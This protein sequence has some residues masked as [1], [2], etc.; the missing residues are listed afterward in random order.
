[1]IRYYEASV[2]D[3]WHKGR[4]SRNQRANRFSIRETSPHK[5]L[6]VNSLPMNCEIIL[7]Q[8][9]VERFRYQFQIPSF[10]I[11]LPAYSETLVRI[12]TTEKGNRL[13]EAQKLQENG[14]CAS[15]VVECKDSSFL[16]LI[17]NLNYTGENLKKFPRTQ[18]LTKLSGRFQDATN[19][20]SHIRKQILQS[21][22]RLAHIKEG[23]ENIRQICAEYMSVFKLTGDKLT[24]T[25]AITHYIPTPSIPANRALTLRNY[26]IPEYHQKEVEIQI[27]KMLEGN[28]VKPSQC[29]WNFPILIVPKKL[30]SSGK[31]K[32][33]NMCRLP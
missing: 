16:C 13:V 12:P 7:G 20:E 26:R 17:I 32:M 9:W 31:L 23:E 6:M 5:F 21:Q 19:K 14:F 1:M 28:I 22:L 18:E 8:D 33:A 30:D 24:A 2:K 4:L 3:S 15:S 27:K 10:G 11:N 25:S 29:P